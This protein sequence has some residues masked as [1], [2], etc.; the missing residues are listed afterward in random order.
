MYQN[1]RVCNKQDNRVSA[2]PVLNSWPAFSKVLKFFTKVK[3]MYCLKILLEDKVLAE[4]FTL[5]KEKY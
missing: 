2:N 5:V 4:N 1:R 3:V